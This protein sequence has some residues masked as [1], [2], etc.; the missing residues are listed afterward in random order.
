QTDTKRQRER[1][2]ERERERVKIVIGMRRDLRGE[3]LG[4]PTL[5]DAVPCWASVHPQ[6]S[7]NELFQSA[8][9]SLQPRHHHL[10]L[11][12][13]A[14]AGQSLGYVLLKA[15]KQTPRQ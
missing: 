14:H 15:C 13:P 11:S 12:H 7:A 4:E 8:D 6:R 9:L 3:G 1:A 2:R 5:R 10:G